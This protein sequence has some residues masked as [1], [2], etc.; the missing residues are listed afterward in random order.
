MS[1]ARVAL[2]GRNLFTLTQIDG[3]DPEA[4]W[5]GATAAYGV[6]RTGG[7]S[8]VFPPT[9]D[10]TTSRQMVASYPSFRTISAVLELSF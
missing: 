2:I 10:P 8:P 7:V 1:G 9:G 6:A 5:P 3:W 4:N